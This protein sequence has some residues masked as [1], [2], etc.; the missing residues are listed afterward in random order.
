MS[1]LALAMF[2]GLVAWGQPLLGYQD[3]HERVQLAMLAT[4]CFGLLIGY[5]AK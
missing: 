2:V 1:A 4:F 3:P 5:R